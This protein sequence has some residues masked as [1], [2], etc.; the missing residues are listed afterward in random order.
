[1]KFILVNAFTQNPAS[2]FSKGQLAKVK[3]KT[4]VDERKMQ[5]LISI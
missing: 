2:F 4:A 5:L 3:E 1:M